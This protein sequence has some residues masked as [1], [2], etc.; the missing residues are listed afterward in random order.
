MD[1]T[2]QD[3][4]FITDI[5]PLLKTADL[6]R[7]FSQHIEG[8]AFTCF[9]YRHRPTSSR[10]API[11]QGKIDV[12]VLLR[13]LKR[14]RSRRTLCCT[15]LV[16]IKPSNTRKVLAAFEDSWFSDTKCGDFTPCKFYR[17]SYAPSHLNS[18]RS[19]CAISTLVSSRPSDH[20][21]RMSLI[22]LGLCEFSPPSWMPYGNV[23]TPVSHFIS[24]IRSCRLGSD[25]IRKLRLD[26]LCFRSNRKYG[27]VSYT[28]PD[29]AGISDPIVDMEVAME[30]SDFKTQSGLIL[31][32]PVNTDEVAEEWDRFGTLHN[33][34]YD[35]DRSSKHSLKYEN[36]IELKWEKGGSGL[37]HYTDEMFWRE[38]ESVR[39]DEFFDE[40]SSFDWDINLHQYSDDEGLSFTGPGGPDLDSKQLSQILDESNEDCGKPF[41][42][43]RIHRFL[44]IK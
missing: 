19:K 6:R 9:H 36:R 31:S 2:G 34:P 4:F 14:H 42:S 18:L 33:D 23:G 1:L 8:G 44:V 27:S 15:A 37:V 17:V 43:V 25:T 12:E 38:R 26:L 28:Y 20:M 24:L 40:P 39:K 41:L 29:H 32:N 3:I 10:F 16:A 11:V 5:P 21:F 13:V 22:L 7:I 30:K 35:V